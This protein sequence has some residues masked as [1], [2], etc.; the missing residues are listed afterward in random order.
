MNQ[1]I[2]HLV[3]D[4]TERGSSL[5]KNELYLAVVQITNSVMMF[6]LTP[7]VFEERHGVNLLDPQT[8]KEYIDRLVDRLLG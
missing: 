7:R 4:L 3:I 1:F 8:R 2:N 6:V 5:T